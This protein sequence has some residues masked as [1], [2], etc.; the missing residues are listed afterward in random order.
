MKKAKVWLALIFLLAFFLRIYHL[1]QLG[2][3]GDE[4]DVGYHAYS[5][6]TTGRDYMGQRWPFYVHSLSEW[7]APLLMYATMP[8]LAVFRLNTWGVRLPAL[9]FG[10][11]DIGFLF[12]LINLVF[13]DTRL[14]LL[15]AFLLAITPWHIH[16]SRAAFEVTLLLAL[17]L[18]AVGG[19]W[20]WL[21]KENRKWL[22]LGTIAAVLSFYTYSTANLFVPLLFGWIFFL[23]RGAIIPAWRSYLIPFL[24]AIIA[25]VPLASAIINGPGRSR[26]Q[27]I[28]IFNNPKTIDRIVFK[29]NTGIDNKKIARL[30]HNKGLAWS[31][32]FLVNYYQAFSPQFLFLT[33]DPNPRHNMPHFG[34]FSWLLAPFLLLGLLRVSKWPRKKAKQKWLLLGWLFIAPLPA[35]LTV[36]GGVQATRLFLMLPPLIILIALGLEVV[37]QQSQFIFLAIITAL[38]LNLIYWQHNYFLHYPREQYRYWDDG[39]RPAIIWLRENEAR[40]KRI[41]INEGHEPALLRYLFWCQYP[42]RQF[43]RIF[44]GDKIHSEVLPGLDGFRLGKVI[45]GIIRVKDKQAWLENNLRPGDLYLAFQEDEVPG[46]WDW[47]R[48]PP[49]DIKILKVIHNPWGKPV[50]YWLTIK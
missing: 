50:M 44:R 25:L 38:I 11:L 14:S 17:V 18:F 7:R 9:F 47:G 49:A 48:E 26:F 41:I 6:L 13:N 2:L 45:F 34:E 8:F 27:L 31:R 1:N 12:W 4:L 30:W 23:W 29:R 19:Y 42:P 33:G 36:A 16:Y 28:S 21:K 35:A 3:F 10:L 22:W 32:A 43:Q 39:Y 24:A 15:A 46:D 20:Q 40:Y 37:Y 5:L